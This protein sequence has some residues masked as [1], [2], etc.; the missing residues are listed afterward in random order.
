MS[1]HD[2]LLHFLNF[3]T[4]MAE[5]AE[6]FKNIK[7]D[8]TL[9]KTS[10]YFGWHAIWQ[11]VLFAILGGLGILSIVTGFTK[12]L[13]IIF[14]IF[15]VV[16]GIALLLVSLEYF[17]YALNSTIKQLRLNRRAISW[18]ALII[19]ILGTIALVGV[20]SLVFNNI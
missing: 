19:F 10:K 12:F 15:L 11:T 9:R 7:K 3:I 18:I 6:I 5:Y 17:I 20:A 4:N 14:N 16:L 13:A 1:K 2:G 8:E